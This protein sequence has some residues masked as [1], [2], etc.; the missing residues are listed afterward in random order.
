[1]K[2]L[3]LLLSVFVFISCSI[4][5]AN[6][7]DN[8]FLYS[9]PDEPDMIKISDMLSYKSA[10][11]I[12]NGDDYSITFNKY[13]ESNTSFTL[14][15]IKSKKVI[16]NAYFSGYIP[17]FNDETQPWMF[18]YEDDYSY[19]TLDIPSSKV[20][21]QGEYEGYYYFMLSQLIE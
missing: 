9:N 8:D 21:P 6:Y 7:W 12:P 10:R 17:H 1:V 16:D 11:T 20:R 4:E 15:T 5:P 19:A 13:T 14:I 18:Y 2:K 3:L